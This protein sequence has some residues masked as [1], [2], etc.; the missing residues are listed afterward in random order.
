MSTFFVHD[1]KNAASTLNLMLQNLPVHFNDPA[2]REGTRCQMDFK[3]GTTTYESPRGPS[4]AFA[5]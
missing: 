1:L 2:F 3:D 5:P 4:R